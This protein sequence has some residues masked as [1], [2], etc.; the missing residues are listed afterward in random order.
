MRRFA[1][2]AL[3]LGALCSGCSAGAGDDGA[4]LSSFGPGGN[5]SASTSD[6][7]GATDTSGGGNTSGIGGDNASCC[8]SRAEPGCA[9]A[10]VQACVCDILPTCCETLW[11]YVC[12]N[13]AGDEC[14]A[15]ECTDPGA[16]DDSGGGGGTTTGMGGGDD[17]NPP[18]DPDP[19]PVEEPPC[20]CME[21]VN[22]FCCY[23]VN[24]PDCPP[25]QPGGYCDPDGDGSFED[26]GWDQ[27][28]YDYNEW[29]G[30]SDQAC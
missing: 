3:T 9:D 23:G 5:G 4:G 24:N 29:C 17:T 10:A 2:A 8:Q 12:V 27:G 13:V 16:V 19:P 22:N 1:F 26:G 21:G 18:P 30:P 6:T 15:A 7:D 14:G 20:P 28:W 11:S 25:T